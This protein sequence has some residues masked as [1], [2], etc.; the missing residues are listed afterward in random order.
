MFIISTEQNIRLKLKSCDT[1]LIGETVNK[2]IET[3][4]ANGT[5]ANVI[6]VVWSGGNEA[7]V[8]EQPS[9]R[10]IQL[11]N[12]TPEAMEVLLQLE[13]PEGVELALSL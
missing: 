5:E 13:L 3:V 6:T 12:P 4:I 2:I 8:N 11:S 9:T 10:Y 7:D 1:A